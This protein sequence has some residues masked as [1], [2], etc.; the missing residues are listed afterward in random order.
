MGSGSVES[1][2]KLGVQARL[3]GAGMPWKRENVNPMLCLRNARGSQRGEDAWR[4]RRAALRDA[5]TQHRSERLQQRK[6][7]RLLPT[8]E[9]RPPREPGP[10][11]ALP[12][13]P[14]ALPLSPCLERRAP[15]RRSIRG[16]SPPLAGSRP[17]LLLQNF[18][19]HPLQ[20]LP[21]RVERCEAVRCDARQTAPR[22]IEH[23]AVTAF[24]TGGA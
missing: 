8:S 9:D 5:Q 7:R 3:K 20:S 11:S 19:P 4:E 18:E 16:G 14:S 22:T 24:A 17:L 1:A 6:L 10:T 21:V 23:Q 13:P 15:L 12:E 2:N